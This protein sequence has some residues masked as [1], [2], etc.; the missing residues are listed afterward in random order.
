MGAMDSA[1]RM[2]FGIN[3]AA[4]NTDFQNMMNQF[5]KYGLLQNSYGQTGQGIQNLDDTTWMDDAFSIINSIPGVGEALTA[6]GLGGGKDTTE[7]PNP[8]K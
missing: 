2:G 8:T 7:S 4:Q 5:R 6:L 3:S 1:N